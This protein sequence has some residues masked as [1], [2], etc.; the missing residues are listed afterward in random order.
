MGKLC[1]ECT[2]IC[3]YVDMR[4]SAFVSVHGLPVAHNDNGIYLYL[5]YIEVYCVV[6]LC[7]C[8]YILGV[9]AIFEEMPLISLSLSLICLSSTKE[10]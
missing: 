6:D 4:V 9:N 5:F 7:I 8:I 1:F 2:F 3:V 10:S